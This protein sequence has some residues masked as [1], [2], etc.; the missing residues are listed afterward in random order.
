[1]GG[2]NRSR[3]LGSLF[4]CPEWMVGADKRKYIDFTL[5]KGC[6]VYTYIE[7]VEKAHIYA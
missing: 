6:I 5:S 1:M 7:S 2:P 4:I 3:R